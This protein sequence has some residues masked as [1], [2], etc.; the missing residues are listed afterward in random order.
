MTKSSIVLSQAALALKDTPVGYKPQKGLPMKVSVRYNSREG[1]QPANFTFSNV[2][3]VWAHN[4]QTYIQDDPNNPGS[5]VKRVFGGGGA[6]DYAVMA[7]VEATYVTIYDSATGKFAPESYDSSV[8]QRL[9]AT[10]AATSYTRTLPDGTVETYGLTDGATTAPRTMFL[11]SIAD[12]SGNTTTINYD[13]TFRLTT[14]TDA[15]GRSTTFSYTIAG[16]PL[17]VSKVTDPFGRFTTLGYDASKRL[18]SVTDPVN[19][20]SSFAYNKPSEPNFITSLTTPYGTSSFSDTLNPNDPNPNGEVTRSLVAK[21]PMGFVEY[22]YLYQ[23]PTVTGTVPE[24]HVPGTMFND[25]NTGLRNTYFWNKHQ[26]ASGG[27]TLDVNGNPIAQNWANASI[28]HWFMQCCNDNYISS[29]LMSTK[30]PLESAWTLTM[31]DLLTSSGAKTGRTRDVTKSSHYTASAWPY[32]GF[33][34]S[35]T[36]YNPLSFPLTTLDSSN[37]KMRYTY[38]ANNID[39]LTAE[40]LYLRPNAFTEW[41]TTTDTYS[42]YTASHLPQTYTDAAGQVWQYTYTATGQLKTITDPNAGVTTYNYDASAHVR[43]RKGTCSP[44]ITTISTVSPKS[45]TLMPQRI[46]M[47]TPSRAARLWERQALTCANA[48][49]VWGV[50]PRIPMMLTAIC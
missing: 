16:S 25:A 18:A 36:T 17:L 46:C 9:P 21:D 42:N 13:G 26:S 1:E 19:I 11:T 23:N 22:A 4:W 6:Y 31:Q 49:T 5:G 43:M 30:Q 38:A 35:E 24:T 14:I 32:Q 37:R 50:L 3:P 7:N 33:I 8:L 12:P 29:S 48:Q 2:G 15:M 20:V 39:L 27:V 10:G 45:P 47:I 41:Y 34:Y 40:R 28:Y 44:M